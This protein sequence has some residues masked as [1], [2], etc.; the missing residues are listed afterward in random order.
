[1][2]SQP[3]DLTG[4]QYA[5]DRKVNDSWHRYFLSASGVLGT[6]SLAAARTQTLAWNRRNTAGPGFAPPGL[7]RITLT[8]PAATSDLQVKEFTLE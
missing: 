5:I 7:Y 1:R 2:G 3:V 6:Q 8:V 4:A